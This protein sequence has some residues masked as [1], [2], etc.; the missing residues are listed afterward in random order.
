MNVISVSLFFPDNKVT[1]KTCKYVIGLFNDIKVMPKY[2]PNYILIIHHDSSVP[3]EILNKLKHISFIKL[4]FHPREKGLTLTAARFLPIADLDIEN[5]LVRDLDEILNENDS[6]IVQSWILNNQNK[7]YEEEKK[8]ILS[9]QSKYEKNPARKFLA[10]HLT[11]NRTICNSLPWFTTYE[12]WKQKD[13][14]K[15]YGMDEIFLEYMF[16]D[17]KDIEFK[18]PKELKSNNL[19]PPSNRVYV[20]KFRNWKKYIEKI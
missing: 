8:N 18:S 17:R 12:E 3:E 15:E 20:P 5:F 4:I 16:K 7:K 10:G 9:Y 6:K 1:P 2:F 11:Y 19:F 14:F 13:Q